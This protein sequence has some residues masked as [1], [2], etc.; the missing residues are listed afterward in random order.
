MNADGI[1]LRATKSD[2]DS[3]TNRVSTA[4]SSLTVQ[5]GQIATKVAQSD[6]NTLTNRVTSA[7]SSI[8]QQAGQIALRV[9]KAGIVSAI[10]QTAESIKISASKID[11]QGAVTFSSLDSSTQTKINTIESTATTAKTTAETASSNATT[12]LTRTNDMFDD[13]KVTPLE[14]Q[15]LKRLWDSIK[16]EYTQIIAMATSL[17][18]SATNYTNA[19]NALNSTT[20]RIET[21]ILASMTTTYSF[22]TTTNRDTFN[23]QLNTYF[24]QRE[25][26]RKSLSDKQKQIADGAQSTATS[27]NTTATTAKSTADTAK[28]TA[29]TAQST[30]TSANTTATTA[31]STADTAKSTAD[32]AKATADTASSN[33]TTALSRTNEMF[34][35]LKVTPPEK[36]EL[37]RL[38]DSIKLEYTQIIAMATSLSVSATNYTSSFNALNSTA[39]RIETDV[40]ASMTTTYSF[41]TTTNRDTFNTQITNYF[42]QREALRKALSDKQK[43]IADNA[44]STATTANT[45]AGTAKTT[46]DTAKT[47]ADTAKTT[48]D[49]AQ[50]TATTANT[51]ATTAKTTADTAKSTADT[52]KSTADTASSNATSAL[53]KA[54]DLYSDLKITPLE[55]QELKRMWDSI[56]LE[57][58]QLNA[59]AVSLSVSASS[60]TTAYSALNSTAPRIETDILANMTTTYDLVNTTNKNTFNTQLTNYFTQ[61]EA[62]RKAVSDKQKQIAD[63]AQDKADSAFSG[64]DTALEVAKAMAVGKLVKEDV[65]FQSG[66]NG[67]NLYNNASNGAVTVTRVAKPAD[68]PTISTH[69]MKITHTGAGSPGYGGFVQDIQSRANAKFVVRY[70]INLPVGY[71]LNTASNAM[72]T[73]YKDRLLGSVDGTGKYTEYIR[74]I[75]CGKDGT[76]NG[77]GHIYVSGT[78]TPTATV[79][80]EWYLASIELY[81]ITDWE[82]VPAGVTKSIEDAQ[83][84]ATDALGKTTEMFSD[85]KITP[86]EKQ[87]LKRLWDSIK[88]EYPQIIAMGTALSVATSSYTTAYTALNGTAPRIET[89]VL[90]SM[91]TTYTLTTATRDTFDSQMNAYVTQREA[92]R[93][94]ITD[95][96][97]QLADGAQSTATSANTLAGT[98]NS[99]ANTAK[100]KTD[101]LYSDLK[102]TPLEKQELKRLWDSIKLEYTQTLAMGT[103]LSVATTSYTTAY[104]ALNSTAPRIETDILAN[105]TTTYDLVNTT[106]KNTFSTQMNNYVTHR[107][108]LKKAIVDK[109]KKLA[110]DAQTKA[111]SVDDLTKA[112]VH[113]ND[114][115]YI[116]GGKIY[117]NTISSREIGVTSLSA[118]SANIGSVN[119]GTISGVSF[120]SKPIKVNDLAG[121]EWTQKTDIGVDAV[122][123]KTTATMTLAHNEGKTAEQETSVDHGGIMLSQRDDKTGLL[124]FTSISGRSIQF[125]GATSNLV[126]VGQ[127]FI[128]SD[129]E[130]SLNSSNRMMIESFKDDVIIQGVKFKSGGVIDSEV[131]KSP[132][133]LN[134]YTQYAGFTWASYY[135]DPDGIVHVTGLVRTG[136]NAQGT[137]MFVLPVGYRPSGTELFYTHAATAGGVRID[138]YNSGSVKLQS[139]GAGSFV[140]F[141]G[142]SFKAEA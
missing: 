18:V 22:G 83:K 10:N 116:N 111:T 69:V 139:A 118:I 97:K 16:L 100:G 23:T 102:I 32:T 85:L 99:T 125:G 64:A 141:A 87:E 12:A 54:N 115:T 20:P 60:Y 29:D 134:G 57:Y 131:R 82:P 9:E 75:E 35:D 13:L 1:A 51:T 136:N 108:A 50:S 41:G 62:L 48:A 132:I 71:K 53:S 74:V 43:Q 61:R 98:A 65:K 24:T 133:L 119:A 91:N 63:N 79:P 113:A 5:S 130:F 26:L 21:D 101:E 76:F 120:S 45:T 36:Q 42:T 44:Q 124:S 140:S 123:F 19:F 58:T 121:R 138:V 30:A 117:T 90:A 33:A 84:D 8:T 4:E 109:Q 39:P 70:L 92:L 86:L 47:T 128:N 106:N 81:D 104:N 142:I 96:Q 56:K 126:A 37:K 89:D 137:E 27:A 17:T 114:K 15:D 66:T 107:E 73:G 49:T 135:K 94:A 38:W 2:L 34:D 77:G 129:G 11:I 105:M 112:W 78:T 59:M 52:A 14:K 28:A 72:G 80:L 122:G 68:A 25:A 31:K 67:V 46:A 127:H 93:K 103:A 3:L 95:K 7:E 110:D 6:F 55:K 40:L 88:I